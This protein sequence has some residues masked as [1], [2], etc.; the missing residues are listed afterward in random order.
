MSVFVDTSAFYAVLDASD[1][2]HTEARDAWHRLLDDGEELV[3][4]NY[5]LVET[6][7][8]L[9]HRLGMDAIQAFTADIEPVVE[10]LWVDAVTHRAALH[11]LLV[12]GRRRVS[13]VDCVSFHVMRERSI[14][15]AFCFDPH[16]SE[17][18]FAVIPAATSGESAAER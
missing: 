4:S 10:R 17:Q 6:I 16:F 18:G 7:S 13:L 11:A 14:A 15:T 2:Y 5:T 12:S 8:L 1:R 9:Q 3:S